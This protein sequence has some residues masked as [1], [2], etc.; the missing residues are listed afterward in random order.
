MRLHHAVR[1]LFTCAVL[2]CFALPCH[3]QKFFGSAKFGTLGI[4]ADIGYETEIPI[5]FRVNGN[6]F[7]YQF[8]ESIDDIDY[9]L[10]VSY[11]SIGTLVDWHPF[12]SAFRI[13]GGVYYNGLGIDLDGQ[14]NSGDTVEIGDSTFDADEVG[15]LSAELDVNSI[16]PYFGI[17]FGNN[18]G[19]E[20]RNLFFSLDV[21]ILYHGKPDTTLSASN[22]G[23]LS[24]LEEELV[25]EEENINDD[26]SAFQVFP[27]IM[28]GIMYRF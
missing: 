14:L 15:T 24:L 21:G 7:Y 4:G 9:E 11:P 23:N 1:V 3:A 2:F 13:T 8:D 22:P 20:E 26:V 16:A 12:E 28:A 10:E 18:I 5:S 17:G 19:A 25:R 27:V 6:F